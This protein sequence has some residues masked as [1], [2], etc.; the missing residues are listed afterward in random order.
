MDQQHL[1]QRH[2]GERTQQG[3]K[4]SRRECAECGAP[5]CALRRCTAQRLCA[6]CRQRPEHKIW[7]LRRVEER[8]HLTEDVVADLQV[9]WTVNPRD[10]RF[11]RQK[12][13]FEK[14]VLMRVCQLEG[15]RTAPAP[16]SGAPPLRASRLPSDDEDV[17]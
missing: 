1:Q 8:T 13:Y 17:R 3:E 11:A 14:D 10:P 15:K 6:V 7:T 4:E 5:R 16:P 2:P 9:G 12:I